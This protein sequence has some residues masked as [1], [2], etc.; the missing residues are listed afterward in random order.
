MDYLTCCRCNIV[1]KRNNLIGFQDLQ[2]QFNVCSSCITDKEKKQLENLVARRIQDHYKTYSWRKL[3]IQ[4]K[5]R[6][7]QNQIRSK[8]T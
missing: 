4:Q 7:Y 6:K 2:E 5:R 1:F 8:F 3:I